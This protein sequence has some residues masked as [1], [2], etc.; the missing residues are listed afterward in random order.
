MMKGDEAEGLVS[1]AFIT[2]FFLLLGAMCIESTDL[3][4]YFGE[5]RHVLTQCHDHVTCGSPHETVI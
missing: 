3:S 2:I 1:V 5:N 4:V